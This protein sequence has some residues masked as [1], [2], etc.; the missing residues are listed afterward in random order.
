MWVGLSHAMMHLPDLTVRSCGCQKLSVPAFLK[1]NFP[2]PY[3][4]S[5]WINRL[6]LEFKQIVRYINAKPT[7]LVS[8]SRFP[9]F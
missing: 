3:M 8:L 7:P 5:L 4:S 9:E 1:R 6:Y 2:Y